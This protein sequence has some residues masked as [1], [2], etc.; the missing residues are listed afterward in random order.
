MRFGLLQTPYGNSGV[1]IARQSK[2][3]Q[4][5]IKA[6]FTEGTTDKERALLS[7]G[8]KHN[9]TV[10]GIGSDIGISP[11]LITQ[12]VLEVFLQSVSHTHTKKST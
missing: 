11:S 3:S 4:L 9:Q 10:P 2:P 7:L 1:E 5:A 12:L 8:T 6:G